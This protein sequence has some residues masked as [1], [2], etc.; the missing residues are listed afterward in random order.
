MMEM[1]FETMVA[2]AAA[3]LSRRQ[4]KPR[5]SDEPRAGRVQERL[6]RLIRHLYDCADEGKP[7]PGRVEIATM[8]GINEDQVT[9]YMFGARTGGYLESRYR[10][11]G[12]KANRV[13]EYAVRRPGGPWTPW[14]TGERLTRRQQSEARKAK[15]ERR[16]VPV[17]FLDLKPKTSPRVKLRAGM[18]PSTVERAKDAL[19]AKGFRPVYH[20][21]TVDRPNG[22]YVANL[23]KPGDALVNVGGRIMTERQVVA[24]ANGQAA[25]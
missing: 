25:Q 14:P 3:S 21:D 4:G 17:E 24:L 2:R 11:F 9:K 15:G 20:V 1:Q 6:G 18:S 22:A 23:G 13:V 8:L 7:A 5:K 12:A 19:R 16:G 10:I